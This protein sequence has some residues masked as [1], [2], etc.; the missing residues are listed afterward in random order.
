M[1]HN[2]PTLSK[3]RLITW[4]SPYFVSL[5]LWAGPY[6]V[7][8][9]NAYGNRRTACNH[10]WFAGLTNQ[11]N[12]CEAIF[13]NKTTKIKLLFLWKYRTT[14]FSVFHIEKYLGRA[15]EH[16]SS[17]LDFQLSIKSTLLGFLLIYNGKNLRCRIRP[18][19]WWQAI[20]LFVENRRRLTVF[21]IK[22]KKCFWEW[23]SSWVRI[24][25]IA[26]GKIYI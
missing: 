10:R 23:V 20:A 11:K 18:C 26:A 7:E 25:R 1:F 4:N 24:G 6:E 13:R 5:V 21:G 14:S 17:Y 9:V 12:K 22:D 3:L 19:R 8:T 16:C 2:D 15:A